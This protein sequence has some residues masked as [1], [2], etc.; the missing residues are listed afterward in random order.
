MQNRV[1]K[2]RV[3][4]SHSS[5]DKSF[6]ERLAN[7]L[8]KCQIEPWLDT[9]EIRDGKPWLKVIFE[10]GIPTCDAVIIY[11]TENS[12]KSKM[13]AK[14]LDATIVEQLGERGISVLPYVS[15]VELRGELR[16]DIRT[17]Q[18]REW[19]NTNY[20]EILPSVVAEIWRSY[21]EVNIN[22]AV[23]QERNARLELELKL[24]ELNESLVDSA[25]SPQEEKEFQY[26]HRILDKTIQFYRRFHS[27]KREGPGYLFG[28][29]DNF[30]LS[31]LDAVIN[32]VNEGISYYSYDRFSSSVNKLL[33]K[34]SQAQSNQ[35]DYMPSTCKTDT[36]VDLELLT[37]GLINKITLSTDGEFNG[38]DYP[39][40]NKMYRFRYWLTYNN[41]THE[42]VVVEY[43]GTTKN[44]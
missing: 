3:F 39:F 28:Y 33:Q 22:S 7:D 19:N 41:H 27:I 23:L 15:K 38:Y 9:E 20:S 43:M 18:C 8:R 29:N 12:I 17:L 25:F 21:M 5:L 10:D 30:K 14:E 35:P 6:I 2:P 37:Y 11:L 40:T 31:F 44:P 42:N 24:K 32:Y 16:V 4:L 36:S 13:V 26:L 34:V 1:N